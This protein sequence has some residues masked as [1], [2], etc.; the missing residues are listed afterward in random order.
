ME[1]FVGVVI[2]G[3]MNS[4]AVARAFYE[5]YKIKT[6]ILG[7]Y[8]LFFID[9]SK[10][11][12]CYFNDKILED[13]VVVEELRKIDEKY[14]DTKK[15]LFSNV[16]F[17]V[18]L[19]IYNKERILNISDNF[20][21][22]MT[23]KNMFDELFNK[24]S[25]YK[26]CEKYDLP[27]PKTV[28]FDMEKDNEDKFYIPY[29]F[30]IFLKPV[31]SDVYSRMKF[32]GRQKGYKINSLDEFKSVI[33]TIRENKYF[34]KFII[35]EYI[36]SLDEDMYVFTFYCSKD[37]KVQVCTAGKILM[38]DR[39]PSLIGNYNAITNF[40]NEELSLKLK[41]FL[42]K[43]KFNG[44]CH[45]DVIYDRNRDKYYVLEINVR[46]GRSNYYTAASGV[47]LAS[48]IVDDYIN[49][50]DKEFTI[51]NNEFVVSIIPKFILKMCLKEN[52]KF[53]KGKKFFRF[54]L[55][56][57][58]LNFKRLFNQ[59]KWDRRIIKSFFKYK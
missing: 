30:P 54:C 10:I 28:V 12:E 49:N 55:A 16:D 41:S 9:N 53:I 36:E 19:V 7:Q 13:D 57:Y 46:Q 47:N 35:Q 29:D 32:K 5:K 26:L 52:K 1:K 23:S 31:N 3:D 45:F 22:P 15:I 33:K 48:Y 37:Y 2:G 42:E 43:I 34:G 40:Y 44:I 4:Y 18:R 59:I 50:I 25:F 56:K 27:C 58:D 20:I 14:P 21:I 17:Y 51:I 38:H 8:P 24:D 11:C 6:I 39:S